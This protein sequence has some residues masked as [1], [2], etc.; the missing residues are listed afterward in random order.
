VIYAEEY[1]VVEKSKRRSGWP[2][3]K[4]LKA[5]VIS[6]TRYYR[7]QRRQERSDPL[8][9][10]QPFEA[11]E[12]EKKEVRVYALKYPGIRH[13]D[14]AWKMVDEGVACLS[15]STVYRILREEKLVC[16][17]KRRKKRKREDWERLP[18]PMKD[19]ERT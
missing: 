6:V 2:V 11:L 1:G 9:R 10:S 12:E 19:G 17:W 3:R 14:L 13:R 18:D 16:P 4:T 5:M 15:L 8:P 7:W